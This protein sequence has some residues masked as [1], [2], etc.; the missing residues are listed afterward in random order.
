M[1][2]VATTLSTMKN[3]LSELIMKSWELDKDLQTLISSLREKR[4]V[5]K[6]YTFIHEQLRKNE[7]LVVGPDDQLRKDILQVWHNTL[8]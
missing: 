7:R 5:A 3:D 6:G 8:V 4:D 2:V 1:K